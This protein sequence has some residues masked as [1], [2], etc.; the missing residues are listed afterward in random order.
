MEVKPSY[1][2]GKIKA[3]IQ[4]EVDIPCD[5]QELIYNE[6]VL[7]NTSTL[8]DCNINNKSTLTVMSKSSEYMPIFINTHLRT[9]TLEVKP[10]NTIRNIKSKIQDEILI[11]HYEQELIFND[12]VLDN[13]SKLDDFP[14]KRESTITL[15]R[16]STGDICIFIKTMTGRIFI[17]GVKPSDTIHNVKSMIHDREHI[18]PCQQ[19]LIFNGK[20]LEDGPTIADYNITGR[21]T[22]HLNV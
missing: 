20:Q 2:I 6:M 15:M 9:I 21:S 18:P 4:K 19:R 8:A 13:L 5:E 1:N 3:N 11:P 17:V 10:S 12:M 14:I 16:I 7:N 22:L